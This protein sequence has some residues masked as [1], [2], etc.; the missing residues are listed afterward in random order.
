VKERKTCEPQQTPNSTELFQFLRS[1][2]QHSLLCQF[3]RDSSLLLVLV[4]VLVLAPLSIRVSQ[5]QTL[6]PFTD[7]FPFTDGSNITTTVLLVK[8]YDERA[9]LGGNLGILW[10]RDQKHSQM[11]I[12]YTHSL[13]QLLVL[14]DQIYEYIRGIVAVRKTLNAMT[15]KT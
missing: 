1:S 7:D 3:L 14:L 13:H 5:E 8:A 6:S 11:S 4:L 2:L 9:D 15:G 10:T 12:G